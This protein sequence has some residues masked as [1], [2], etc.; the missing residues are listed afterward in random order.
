MARDYQEAHAILSD[1]PKS[2]AALARRML[3]DVLATYGGY[4]QFLLS[5]RLDAFYNDSAHACT[6]LKENA[7]Y[8]V[9]IGN[10]GAHTQ[11]DQVTAVVVDVE[12]DEAEWTLNVVNGLFDYFIVGPARDRL[13]KQRLAEKLARSGR[14]PVQPPIGASPPSPG[15]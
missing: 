11:K 1:S 13:M 15:P 4:N 9:E 10:F 14:R 2:A 12:P 5:K 6:A 8:L 3:A 7:A